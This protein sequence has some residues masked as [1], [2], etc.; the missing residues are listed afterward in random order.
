MLFAVQ[1]I[2]GVLYE[3]F[4]HPLTSLPS[5]PPASAQSRQKAVRKLLLR[6]TVA[7]EERVPQANAL[8]HALNLDLLTVLDAHELRS[9][10]DVLPSSR[11]GMTWRP[12][13]EEPK[14]Q[15]HQWALS[16]ASH[17][18]T[19]GRPQDSVIDDL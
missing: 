17:S 12:N 7:G 3:S 4:M 9:S 15:Y 18:S 2:R 6:T 8:G 16:T 19:L 14:S 10:S 13:D 11:L 5:L 1:I